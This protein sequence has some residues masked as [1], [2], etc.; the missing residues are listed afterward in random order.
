[1]QLPVLKAELLGVLLGFE[2]WLKITLNIALKLVKFKKCR[3][4]N[5]HIMLKIRNRNPFTDFNEMQQ[6]SKNMVKKRK[7]H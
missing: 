6:N 7:S 4:Q 1:M 3:E 2:E 5:L